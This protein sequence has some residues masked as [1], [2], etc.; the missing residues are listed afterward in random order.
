MF[1]LGV[2]VF[3]RTPCNNQLEQGCRLLDISET[4]IWLVHPSFDDLAQVTVSLLLDCIFISF[5]RAEVYL[6]REGRWSLLGKHKQDDLRLIYDSFVAFKI[7]S[8]H[9]FSSSRSQTMI[10]VGGTHLANWQHKGS[11]R[12]SQINGKWCPKVSSH[13][14]G[15]GSY[16]LLSEVH[17]IT[18]WNWDWPSWRCLQ[19]GFISIDLVTGAL[20]SDIFAVLVSDFQVASRNSIVSAVMSFLCVLRG[21][22]SW[23]RKGW[24]LIFRWVLYA[25]CGIVI[26]SLYFLITFSV[27]FWFFLSNFLQWWSY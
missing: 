21:P 10:V 26:S 23:S 25:V 14:C 22:R 12:G 11:I 13:F 8:S 19:L 6:A 5:R 17:L 2:L 1:L 27:L 3:F 4:V 7:S 9:S 20:S 18:M 24:A 16:K 15:R